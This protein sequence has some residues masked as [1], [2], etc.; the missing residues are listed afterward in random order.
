MEVDTSQGIYLSIVFQ[1]RECI[2]KISCTRYKDNTKWKWT[3]LNCCIVPKVHFQK[4]LQNTNTNYKMRVDTLK[5][6][7]VVNIVAAGGS[8]PL[9]GI[10]ADNGRPCNNCRTKDFYKWEVFFFRQ[11]HLIQ[12]TNILDVLDLID[13]RRPCNDCLMNDIYKWKVFFFREK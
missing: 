4:E 5:E 8:S 13:K 1:K 3:P 2:F 12:W 10:A 7:I 9:S 6:Y 11:M